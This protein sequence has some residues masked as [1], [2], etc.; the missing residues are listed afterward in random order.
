M[1][2]PLPV[3]RLTAR[4]YSIQTDGGSEGE[5]VSYCIVHAPLL[6]M[7]FDFPE[8]VRDSEKVVLSCI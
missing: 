8:I 2:C 6:E 1:D 4:S 3:C 7:T 5:D